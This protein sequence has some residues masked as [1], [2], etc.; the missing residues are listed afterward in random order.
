[1]VN[2]KL[3]EAHEHLQEQVST[4]FR[5]GIPSKD[6]PHVEMNLDNGTKVIIPVTETWDY[7]SVPGLKMIATNEAENKNVLFCIALEEGE[8]ERHSHKEAEIIS[9][10]N[11]IIYDKVSDSYVSEGEVYVIP[12]G[13]EHQV[14]FHKG[15]IFTVTF[16][17]KINK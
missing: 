10:H 12:A 8:T 17:P 2:H 13:R 1:M 3:K 15:D 6:A 9:V 5:D 16:I 14:K 4:M 11:G 7:S